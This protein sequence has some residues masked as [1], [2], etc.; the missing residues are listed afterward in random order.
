MSW[1]YLLSLILALAI[2]V[3]LVV[4]LFFPEKF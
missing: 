1:T 4:A 3:Y 2:F